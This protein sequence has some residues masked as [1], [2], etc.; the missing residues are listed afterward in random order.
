MLLC[1]KAVI[2]VCLGHTEDNKSW[3]LGM[4]QGGLRPLSFGLNACLADRDAW[5]LCP[6]C[7]L[8]DK[9]LHV[10]LLNLAPYKV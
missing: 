2:S 4:P 9:W 5:S 8:I 3:I 1:I 6:K 10:W 7:F